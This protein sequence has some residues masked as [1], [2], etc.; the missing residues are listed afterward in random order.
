MNIIP[1][2]SNEICRETYQEKSTFVLPVTE[3]LERV[4]E[5]HLYS[6]NGEKNSE[7]APM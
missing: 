1:F 2:V 4:W 6:H 3:Q 5:K 7:E